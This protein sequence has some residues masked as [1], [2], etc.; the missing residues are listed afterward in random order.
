M[1]LLL[2]A[3]DV[4]PWEL[5]EQV[6]ALLPARGGVQLY[7]AACTES[8]EERSARNVAIVT[9]F[10]GELVRRPELP[11]MEVYAD[12]AR[13]WGLS[14]KQVQAIIRTNDTAR[15]RRARRAR[16]AWRKERGLYCRRRSRLRSRRPR[17]ERPYRGRRMTRRRLPTCEVHGPEGPAS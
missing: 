10:T 6:R 7:F 15:T 8:G 11:L 17:T 5:L 13:A 16:H 3:P 14:S 9:Q 1:S 12:L 2:R 4:L